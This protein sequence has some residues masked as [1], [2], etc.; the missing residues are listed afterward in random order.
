ME[1]AMIALELAK[2]LLIYGRPM[3]VD[4]PGG[5]TAWVNILHV[6]AI[7]YNVDEGYTLLPADDTTVPEEVFATQEALLTRLQEL[8]PSPNFPQVRA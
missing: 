8:M 1:V 6:Y 2:A 4:M 5:P 3:F 7:R